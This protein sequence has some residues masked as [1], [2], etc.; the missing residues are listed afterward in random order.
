LKL[1]GCNQL[2]QQQECRQEY[3]H[4]SDHPCGKGAEAT[5]TGSA[6]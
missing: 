6:R 2:G 4:G 1:R 5:T 3:A